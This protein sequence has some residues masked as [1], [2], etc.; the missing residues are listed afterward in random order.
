MEMKIDED[1]KETIIII[2]GVIAIT[3]LELKA[4]ELGHD[5][6]ILAASVAAIVGIIT[7]KYGKNR[8]KNIP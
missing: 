5:G 2:G 7:Y 1:M 8:G 6:T 4:L 3:F